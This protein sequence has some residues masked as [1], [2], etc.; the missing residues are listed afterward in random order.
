LISNARCSNKTITNFTIL[1]ELYLLVLG[2]YTHIFFGGEKKEKDG[3]F[4]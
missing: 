1:R 2:G 3:K 4:I